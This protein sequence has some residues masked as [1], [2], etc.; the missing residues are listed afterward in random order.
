MFL[1]KY[2][3]FGAGLQARLAAVFGPLISFHFGELKY[4]LPGQKIDGTKS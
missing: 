2:Q 3:G 4:T 1:G